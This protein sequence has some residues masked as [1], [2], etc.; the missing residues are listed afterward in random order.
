M[1]PVVGTEYPALPAAGLSSPCGLRIG[2][3]G[4]DQVTAA[5]AFYGWVTGLACPVRGCS[6]VLQGGLAGVEAHLRVCHPAELGPWL[7]LRG[8]R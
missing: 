1:V 4:G 8:P 3:P 6:A 5:R 2:A 7:A